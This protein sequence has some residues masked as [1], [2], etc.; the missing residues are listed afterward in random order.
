MYTLTNQVNLL[1]KD[2]IAIPESQPFG[3]IVRCADICNYDCKYC[4]S[5]PENLFGLMTGE[6]ARQ[7]IRKVAAYIKEGRKLHFVWHGGEPLLAGVE[8]FQAVTSECKKLSEFEIENSIQTNGL[9]LTQEIIDFCKAERIA[10]STSIDGPMEIHNMNRRDKKGRGTFDNTM[11]AISLLQNNGIKVHCVTVL[12][13]HSIQKIREIYDFFRDNGIS[14]RVNPVVKIKDGAN[15]YNEL[16]ISPKEYGDA[17]CELFDWWYDEDP[18]IRIE[19]FHTIIGNFMD[20]QV[21]GCDFHGQC[22]KS[23]ISINPNG[24]I[25]PCGRFTNENEF[26]LGNILDCQSLDQVF[27]GALYKKLCARDASTLEGC[28]ECLY[29]TICNGGCMVTGYMARGEIGDRDYYCA[30]RKQIFRHISERL[31]NEFT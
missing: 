24:D 27:A 4:Y 18:S 12:H 19:P 5:K 16:A 7:I 2:K 28:S 3:V 21:W 22:L 17:M 10:I 29:G 1:L 15:S 30:G 14:F 9:L 26:K 25:F 20:T 23:I 8:F 6:V 13:R 31:I 11:A